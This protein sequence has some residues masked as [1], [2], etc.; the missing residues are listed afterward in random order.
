MWQ[1][2]VLVKALQVKQN[3]V[4]VCVCVCTQRESTH[5]RGI[6]F[7]ELTHMTVE[8]GKSK[9]CW[10]DRQAGTQGRADVAV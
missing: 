5:V 1:D 3:H 8:A 2:A 4:C 7:E 9:I 6:D 10:V